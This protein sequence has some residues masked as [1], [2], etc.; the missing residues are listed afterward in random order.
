MQNMEISMLL[1]MLYR[2]VYESDPD[3]VYLEFNSFSL[4]TE[5]ISA[6]PVG[7]TAMSR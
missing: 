2:Y 5:S 1:Y 4:S 6:Y 3:L 7:A